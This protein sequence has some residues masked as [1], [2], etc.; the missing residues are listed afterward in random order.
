MN[1]VKRGVPTLFFLSSF[2][3]WIY[4]LPIMDSE[5]QIFFFRGK[6]SPLP[7]SDFNH[8]N[9]LWSTFCSAP[10]NTDNWLHHLCYSR[11]FKTRIDL[12]H[13]FFR[14]CKKID[15]QTCTDTTLRPVP[16]KRPHLDNILLV[17][18]FHMGEF[19][20]L[21]RIVGTNTSL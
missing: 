18:L 3:Q 4:L 8:P 6:T 16:D 17:E 14:S 9:R 5:T 19:K 20:D 11:G 21:L 15:P 10:T 2:H 1:F 7:P 13:F 12:E